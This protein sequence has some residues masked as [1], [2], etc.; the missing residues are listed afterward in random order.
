MPR[1]CG[2][3]GGSG[4][5]KEHLWPQWVL[6]IILKTRGEEGKKYIVE[7]ERHGR[8]TRFETTNIETK[9]GMPCEGCNNG[10]MSKLEESVKPFMAGMVFPGHLTLLNEDRRRLLARWA[11]KTAMVY[12]FF[13]QDGRF[14][15]SPEERSSFMTSSQPPNDVWVWLG[16]YDATRPMHASQDRK[17]NNVANAIHLYSLTLT[18]NF[19]AVQIVASRDR[20]PVRKVA[21]AE[22]SMGALIRIWPANENPGLLVEWPPRLMLGPTGL[23]VL[24]TRFSEG[25]GREWRSEE[26]ES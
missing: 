26:I 11:V 23:S 10:W 17:I 24:D 19:F 9:V 8:T 22:M 5:S 1:Q 4:V 21:V 13:K 2:F 7:H 14:Y 16:K 25:E 20:G 18:A 3:C 15:F 6:K 12:E